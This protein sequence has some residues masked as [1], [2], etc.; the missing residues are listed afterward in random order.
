MNTNIKKWVAENYPTEFQID[1]IKP[2][3]SFK[4]LWEM[5]KDGKDVY[6]VAS[7]D[8]NGFD[9]AVREEIFNGMSETLNIRYD[10]IYHT[11]LN[12]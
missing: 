4:Q 6:K 12:R 10:T 9:S 3:L 7:V 1:L 5:M 11:W 8:G 2:D